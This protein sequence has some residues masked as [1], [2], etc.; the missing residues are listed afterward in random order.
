MLLSHG[1]SPQKLFC[2]AVSLGVSEST[3]SNDLDELEPWLR[4]H[5]ILLVRKPGQGISAE[6]REEDVRTALGERLIAEEAG[7]EDSYSRRFGYPGEAIESGIRELLNREGEKLDWMTPE[8]YEVFSLYLMIMVER[9]LKGALIGETD[10]PD[11]PFQRSLADLLA[12][13]IEERFSLFLPEEEQRG[14]GLRIQSCRSKQH[15]PLEVEAPEDREFIQV[16][17]ARMIERFDPA[18]APV[19]LTDEGLL[20]GLSRHLVSTVTRLKQGVILPESLEGQMVFQYPEIYEKSRQGAEVLHEYLEVPVPPGEVSLIAIHFLAALSA[21][22][23]KNIR[24][25]VLSAGIVCV[26]GIGMSYMLASQVRKR[27]KGELEIDI[28]GW[29]DREALEKADF[30]I[31]TIPLENIST[32]VV[33]VH[34]LLTEEDYQK[35]REVINTY[36]FVE[37]GSPPPGRKPQLIERIEKLLEVL[38]QVRSMLAAF[39]VE[40]IRGDCPFEELARLAA[41]K[42]AG[43]E[44]GE[45]ALY[46]AL[47]EREAAGTQVIEAMGIVLLHA[48]SP[49]V[50]RPVFALIVPEGGAFVEEYFRGAKSCVLMLIPRNCS[51]EMTGLMG[52]ISGA[53]VDN[54]PLREAVRAGDGPGV[55]AIVEAELSDALAAYCTEHLNG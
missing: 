6:G 51:P 37:K 21:M 23:E 30:I 46:R 50:A 38:G 20:Q 18:L 8:S 3:V 47:I 13:A 40:P 4:D 7:E 39:T 14:I 25:R 53:L 9:V 17:T 2:Y 22:G 29:D 45:D 31:S 11:G 33:P 10:A 42:F 16:L 35:I 28:S 52:H 1:D 19:L 26:A 49:G 55:R 27:F 44:A 54:P 41:E 32:P 12:R 24:R 43:D 36:A 34:I 48:R 15:S 5:G